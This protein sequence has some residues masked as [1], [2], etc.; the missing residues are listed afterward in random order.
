VTVDERT[1]EDVLA[2]TNLLFGKTYTKFGQLEPGE[3]EILCREITRPARSAVSVEGCTFE[4]ED[5]RQP[6]ARRGN[7]HPDRVPVHRCNR[8]D[9]KHGTGHRCDCGA[10]HYLSGDEPLASDEI[11][12]VEHL[13]LILIDNTDRAAALHE[14]LVDLLDWYKGPKTIKVRWSDDAVERALAELLAYRDHRRDHLPRGNHV[15]VAIDALRAV[16]GPRRAVLSGDGV[17]LTIH[18]VDRERDPEWLPLPVDEISLSE[19]AGKV[20][21]ELVGK[22]ITE[23]VIESGEVGEAVY[24]EL[25]PD[26]RYQGQ[27]LPFTVE[28]ADPAA[29]KLADLDV[30]DAELTVDEALARAT[31]GQ[32]ASAL[33]ARTEDPDG[34]LLRGDYSH[35]NRSLMLDELRR[36]LVDGSPGGPTGVEAAQALVK[37]EEIR[38]ITGW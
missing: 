12:L 19:L 24:R 15:L 35:A 25:V 38:E 11:E 31:S 32:L 4:W 33:R 17:D 18:H 27:P 5:R 3:V 2:A 10:V 6:P 20:V 9:P 13:R 16:I 26:A 7:G 22:G 34:E 28:L 36:R 37:L 21:A 30:V 8:H 1:Y 23:L 14:K 29:P